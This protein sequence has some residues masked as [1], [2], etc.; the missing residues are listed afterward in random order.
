VFYYEDEANVE[1]YIQM[2]TGYDGRELMPIL[3]KYLQRGSTVL[4]LGMGPG[5]D[6]GLLAEDYR[7]TGSD[8]SVLF[9][10]RFRRDH[11]QADLVVLDACLMDIER[12]FDCIYSNKVLQH[13]T[14]A[15]LVESLRKQAEVLVAGGILFHTLWYGDGE[16]E[17]SGLC[18]FYYTEESF[19]ELVG[20]EYK[21]LEVGR[22]TE[23]DEGDS[24]Y[25]VMRK[26]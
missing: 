24:L 21:L 8:K 22:Y 9:I 19:E 25:V 16:D 10:E 13:L 7:V 6:L 4:E 2:A 17:Y 11:P 26:V 20:S 15:E 18:T 5:V 23:M 12:S 1:A 14:R 3:R